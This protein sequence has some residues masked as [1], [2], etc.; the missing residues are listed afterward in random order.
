MDKNLGEA[1]Q[2]ATQDVRAAAEALQ[3]GANVIP[4]IDGVARVRTLGIILTTVGAITAVEGGGTIATGIVATIVGIISIFESTGGGPGGG[5]PGSG[6]PGGNPTDPITTTQ[7]PTRTTTSI[8][9]TTSS[10]SSSS[11]SFSSVCSICDCL[12]GTPTP[13]PDNTDEELT[14]VDQD[15]ESVP[16]NPIALIPIPGE[17]S[18]IPDASSDALDDGIHQASKR[19]VVARHETADDDELESNTTNYHQLARRKYKVCSVTYENNDYPN[20][21]KTSKVNA[22][23]I[24]ADA[25]DHVAAITKWIDYELNQGTDEACTWSL[26]RFPNRKNAQQEYASKFM[27]VPSSPSPEELTRSNDINTLAEHIWEKSMIANFLE[28]IRYGSEVLAP[29]Y[30]SCTAINAIWNTR[31]TTPNSPLNGIKPV[32][33]MAAA[34]SDNTR[35]AE[36]FILNADINNV[37][38]TVRP[39]LLSSS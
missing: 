28:W 34:L 8:S 11:S 18:D 16:R 12:M 29:V 31:S 25:A 33:A 24:P 36:F 30:P 1:E 35:V 22:G 5:G 17:P 6:G 38:Q 13:I 3:A 23:T 27:P 20:T 37:K 9:S 15:W 26:R 32:D 4:V 14:G 2:A 7:R 10:S 39:P 19:G 21:A